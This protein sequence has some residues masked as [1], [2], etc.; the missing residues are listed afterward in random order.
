MTINPKDTKTKMA[1]MQGSSG[2]WAQY[3]PQPSV[4][5]IGAAGPNTG[6]CHGL[7]GQES[8]QSISSCIDDK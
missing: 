8:I 7:D 3:N 6:L 1:T 5:F 4:S 2:L